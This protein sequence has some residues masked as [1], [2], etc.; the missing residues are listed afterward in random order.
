MMFASGLGIH[1]TWQYSADPMINPK[2]VR[3]V[4]IYARTS[5]IPVQFQTRNGCGSVVIWTGARADET[6]RR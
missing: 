1:P 3:A 2:D 4:E 6:P 5:S